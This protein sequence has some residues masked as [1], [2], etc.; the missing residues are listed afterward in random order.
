[1]ATDVTVWGAYGLRRSK[2]KNSLANFDLVNSDTGAGTT[3]RFDNQ[4]KDRV[5]TLEA[6]VRGK[7]RT[8]D[9][10]H[11]WVASASFFEQL[12]KTSYKW[13]FF[14]T[15]ATNLYGPVDSALPEFTTG[16]FAGGDLAD[17]KRTGRTRLTSVAIGDTLS[18]LDEH[19]FVTL[20]LR[21]QR[22][23]ITGYSYADESVESDYAK[24]RTSPVAGVVY[25]FAPQF[26]LYGNYIEGLTA[27]DVL[28]AT[29]STPDGVTREPYVAKQTEVGL[30]Y[31]G[32]RFGGGVAFFT[33]SKPRTLSDADSFSDSSGKNEHRGVEF[34]V[35]GEAMR[36]LRLLGG[37]T[38]LD[39]KQKSTGVAAT[40]GKRVIGVSKFQAT[41]GAEWDVPVF[42]GLALDSRVVYA[43]SSYADSANTLKV[44]GWTR[45]DL[46]ARYLTALGDRVLTLRARVDNVTDR[47]YWASVGG[48]P[49][50]GYLVAGAPRTFTLSGSVDF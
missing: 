4:R 10:G 40:D 25:K 14:N 47:N 6:G 7:L 48:Y 23:G 20:G 49:G 1:V 45:L 2:E 32:G 13:D 16:A 31:D 17:P 42:T 39:A 26:S 9:I 33:T 27:G 34:N 28:P 50:K 46:G 22:L 43:G 8:G 18:F 44:S 3:S 5:D 37:G 29:A 38:V 30:K 35:F 19:L 41:V 12:R 21:H 15:Q 36:G 24:E 11:D